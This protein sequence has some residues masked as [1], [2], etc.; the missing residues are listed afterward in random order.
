L[1]FLKKSLI[2]S[3]LFLTACKDAQP[4]VDCNC[5]EIE[6]PVIEE[7]KEIKFKPYSFLKKT[8][9]SDF[10]IARRCPH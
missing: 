8:Y 9:W 2:I 10:F 1:R 5:P 3:F 7:K 6:V 4:P